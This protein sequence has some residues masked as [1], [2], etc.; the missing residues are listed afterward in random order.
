MR[1]SRRPR[2]GAAVPA[3]AVVKGRLVAK[4][5]TQRDVVALSGVTTGTDGRRQVFSFIVNGPASSLTVRRAVDG[6]AATVT[7][8]W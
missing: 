6:L 5:G 8:C 4:T 1:H 3:A 7:G 2:S